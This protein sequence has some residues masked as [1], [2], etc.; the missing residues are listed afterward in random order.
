[1]PAPKRGQSKSRG[2]FRI[3]NTSSGDSRN[4][5]KDNRHVQFENQSQRGPPPRSNQQNGGPSSAPRGRGR[6]AGNA[7]RSNAPRQPRN[8]PPPRQGNAGARGGRGGRGGISNAMTQQITDH[9]APQSPAPKRDWTGVS[10]TS[11]LEQVRAGM[12]SR[13]VRCIALLRL[14]TAIANSSSGLATKKERMGS[15]MERC[16]TRTNR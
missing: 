8:T 11:R 1:M 5:T 6:G 16:P 12:E 4:N 3:A 2:G 13:L 9:I 15:K 14:L 10:N 7:G